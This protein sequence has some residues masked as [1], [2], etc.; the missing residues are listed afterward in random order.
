MYRDPAWMLEAFLTGEK[1]ANVFGCP[2]VARPRPAPRTSAGSSRPQDNEESGGAL[3]VDHDG[4]HACWGRGT[5]GRATSPSRAAASDTSAAPV[6]SG[7]LAGPPGKGIS[8]VAILLRRPRR[9][10]STRMPIASRRLMKVSSRMRYRGASG[11]FTRLGQVWVSHNAHSLTP[12]H[13]PCPFWSHP[14]DY[15]VP[16][17]IIRILGPK[18]VKL[19]LKAGQNWP[20]YRNEGEGFDR[21]GTRDQNSFK[22]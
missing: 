4:T 3:P 12:H 15:Y 22:S 7:T 20:G 11:A 19:S 2:T 13:G 9:T 10:R 21:S 6:V 14:Q 5:A 1:Q 16:A 17:K 8:R 18:D